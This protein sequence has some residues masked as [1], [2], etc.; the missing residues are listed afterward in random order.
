MIKLNIFNMDEFLKV[1]NEC[2]GPVN[3]L[4]ANGKKINI[5]KNETAKLDLER[6]HAVNGNSLLLCLDIPEAKDYLNIV[7]FS[8]GDC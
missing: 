4:S 2:I 7:F 1:V 8:I 5:N 6:K 3:M